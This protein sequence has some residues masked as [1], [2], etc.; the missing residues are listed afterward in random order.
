MWLLQEL[1]F[2]TGGNTEWCSYFGR[3]AVPYNTK[4]DPSIVL[5]GIYPEELRTS[6]KNLN[7]NVCKQNSEAT[8]IY[9]SVGEWINCVQR[10]PNPWY[11]PWPVRN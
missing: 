4:N 10:S 2:T 8:K 1:S 7:T 11:H 3:L 5:L 9:L 6:H